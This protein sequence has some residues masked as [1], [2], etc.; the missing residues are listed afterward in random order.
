M[1]TDP[2]DD[3]QDAP[4]LADLARVLGEADPA[5]PDTVLAARSALAHRAL[6]AEIAALLTDSDSSDKEL[7]GVRGTGGGPR[8]LS[9]A[10]G[11]AVVDLEVEGEGRARL[12]RGQ[13]SP[14]GVVDVV[15]R[16][17]SGS[18]GI[19]ADDLGQFV[20]HAAAGPFSLRLSWRDEPRQVDTE[21]IVL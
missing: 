16:G 12:V 14:P 10:G 7:A 21:W 4:L 19:V 9:F 20:V 3:A 6:D 11:V 5:P 13:C 8:Q 1:T 17:A 18:V 15:A 2:R